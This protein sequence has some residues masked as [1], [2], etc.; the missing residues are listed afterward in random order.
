MSRATIA[1]HAR[2]TGVDSGHQTNV[3]R[4]R[5]VEERGQDRVWY[6]EDAS[7]SFNDVESMALNKPVYPSWSTRKNLIHY[8]THIVRPV[9]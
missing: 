6:G 1:N 5:V 3:D 4:C 2:L 7:E 8:S 9:R